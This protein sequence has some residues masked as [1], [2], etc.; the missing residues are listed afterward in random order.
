MTDQATPAKVRLTD[1]L[2]PLTQTAFMYARRYGSGLTF[3]LPPE[4]AEDVDED[5][6]A[7]KPL[8]VLTPEDVAAVN[9]ARKARAEKVLRRL[10]LC[11]CDHNEYC[12]HCWPAEFRPGG[13][14]G[15]PNDGIQR[16][17]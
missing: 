1:G 17:P 14:W 3:N 5:F 4:D 7:P 2:G 11:R 8:Y 13:V 16:L 6:Q 12:R 10:D 9:A 15:G